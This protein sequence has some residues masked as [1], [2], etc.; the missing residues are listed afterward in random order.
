MHTRYLI[1]LLSVLLLWLTACGEED[2]PTPTARPTQS[3]SITPA[4]TIV[5]TPSVTPTPMPT[6]TPSA[7]PISPEI[8]VEP[9]TIYSDQQ[10]AITA[11]TSPSDGWLAVY[12]DTQSALDAADLLGVIPVGAG[13]N[14]NLVILIEAG[15]ATGTVQI[16]L[17]GG[18]NGT[19]EDL[20]PAEDQLL[21]IETVNIEL[22][23]NP[24]EIT[25]SGQEVFE[26]GVV[27]IQTVS[28]EEAGWL[29]IHNQSQINGEIGQLLGYAPVQA[30]TTQNLPVTIRWREA[31]PTLVAV[32]YADEGESDV[33]EYGA[34]DGIIAY[35]EETVIA[36]FEVT[37]PMDV[38]VF[39]QPVV[40]G[41]FVVERIVSNGPGWLVV[42]QED[43]SG[44]QG[45]IIGTVPLEDGLNEDILVEVDGSAVT[46]NLQLAIHDDTTSGDE[47]D[48]PA[49]DPRRDYLG[50]AVIFSLNTQTGSYFIVRDQPLTAEDQITVDI[51]AAEADYWLVV[52][53]DAA[54]EPGEIIGQTAV[55]AG[56]SRDI[57]VTIDDVSAVTAQLHIMLHEDVSEGEAFN[58]AEDTPVLQRGFPITAPFVVTVQE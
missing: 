21:L 41:E 43:E 12:K 47:F 40:D 18:R 2:P 56:F 45:F 34:A 35:A 57:T 15:E 39:D 24:P 13:N 36:P 5:T 42:Y 30:G 3:A 19:N 52:H 51:I 8:D 17:H 4:P 23:I 16:A 11:V 55:P 6:L 7:T 27:T 32:L 44:S 38:V 25:V 49:N 58:P 14:T 48:F 22:Q 28:H 53:A 50:R 54:G 33:F 37:L 26:D 29:G 46:D 9:Q 1:A 31:N 10:L 20:N